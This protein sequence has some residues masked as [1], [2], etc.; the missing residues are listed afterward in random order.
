MAQVKVLVLG[1]GAHELGH[2]LNEP[3]SVEDLLALPSLIERL[4]NSPKTACYE[5]RPFRLV[6]RARGG[7]A[8]SYKRKVMNAIEQASIKGFA[9]V[10]ILIDRDRQPDKDRI[11][12]L[13]AGRD[14]VLR[15]GSPPCA[16]GTAVE[17]FDA[18][19]IADGKAIGGAGGD[20]SRSHPSPE[21]LDGREQSGRHPKDVVERIFGGRAGLARKYAIV[22][23]EMDLALLEKCCPNGF[24]PFAEE[25][26]RWVEP[27][28]RRA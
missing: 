16:V 7:R 27:A 9:A 1:E 28:V 14:S 6:G 3:L 18:W 13:A 20:Q 10:V 23:A 17:T 22:A 8:R 12:A 19:M 21:K 26:R 25:I 2:R 5:C 4:L 15:A 24:R 11:G